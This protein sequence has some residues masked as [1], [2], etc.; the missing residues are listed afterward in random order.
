MHLICY[1]LG[2]A[3]SSELSATCPEVLKGAEVIKK[4]YGNGKAKDPCFQII[5]LHGSAGFG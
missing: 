3:S 4:V 5:P 1:T 2:E